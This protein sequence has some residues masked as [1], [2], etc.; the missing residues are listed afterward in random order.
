MFQEGWDYLRD[1]LKR[2]SVKIII[3]GP[4]KATI[5]LAGDTQR[6]VLIP[7]EFHEERWFKELLLRKKHKITLIIEE[8]DP[9]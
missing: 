7:K 1:L 8:I 4:F 3:I 6:G 9:E 2:K 5:H